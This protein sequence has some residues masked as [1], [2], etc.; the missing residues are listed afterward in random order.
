MHE[1]GWFLTLTYDEDHVPEYGSLR[2]ADLRAF[3]K[4]LRKKFPAGTLRYFACGEY[5]ELSQRPHYHA[6]LFGPEL[7][8]RCFLRRRGGHPVWRSE[9]VAAHWKHGLHELGTVTRESASYV[10]GYVRKKVSRKAFPDAD[11]RVDP[12][13]GEL[14]EVEPE[15]S[16]MSLRPAIGR[17]WI[18][19]YWRDVYPRDFVVVEGGEYKPPRYYDKWMDENHPEIMLEV[20]EKRYAEMQDLEPEKLRAKEKI[21]KAR[22]ALYER[23][24]EV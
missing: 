14:V 19:K 2:A 18:E 21:R 4:S 22:G 24:S 10:A 7:L 20:R 5:G 8:D 9:T 23:R 12:G 1:Y 16:R 11:V 17:S 15:F 6:V 13:T 3:F